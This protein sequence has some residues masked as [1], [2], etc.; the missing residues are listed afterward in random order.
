MTSWLQK[1]RAEA[2]H[3]LYPIA[4]ARGTLIGC[5]NCSPVPK[6]ILTQGT[7]LDPYGYVRLVEQ[8]T[9]HAY[10]STDDE[11]RPP[12]VGD[13]AKRFCLDPDAYYVL[14][15]AS[16]MHEETYAWDLARGRWVLVGQGLGFA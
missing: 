3:G 5:L 14:H 13:L 6:S 8:R 7:V 2:K 4:P 12:C 10:A 1:R 15:A 11:A 9:V 16:P